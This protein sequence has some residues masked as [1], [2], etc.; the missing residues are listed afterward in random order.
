MP[1]GQPCPFTVD[2]GYPD[3]LATHGRRQP[4]EVFGR[5]GASAEISSTVLPNLERTTSNSVRVPAWQ[6]HIDGDWHTCPEDQQAIFR[7]VRSRGECTVTFSNGGR[8]YEADLVKMLQRN[9]AT[10]YGR[11]LREVL[12]C[13]T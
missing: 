10:G 2:D 1:E 9:I 8:Q 5:S 13:T 4:S 6:V 7:A 11:P 3:C 12:I